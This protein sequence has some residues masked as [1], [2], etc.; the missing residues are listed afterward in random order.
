M[1]YIELPPERKD[2]RRYRAFLFRDEDRT[3]FG[4][5]EYWDDG[6]PSYEKLRVLASK[7]VNNSLFRKSLLSDNPDL[8]LLWKRH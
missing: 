5:K 1:V 4:I 7:V 2:Q 3:L 6:I 8:P